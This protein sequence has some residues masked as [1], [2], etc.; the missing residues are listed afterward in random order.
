MARIFD[1]LDDAVFGDGVN[2]ET[3][4]RRLDRLMMGAIHAEAVHFGDTAEQCTRDNP[5][6][7]TGFIAWIGLAMR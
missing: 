3:R 4:A 2:D 5:D 1:A 6:G 7:V